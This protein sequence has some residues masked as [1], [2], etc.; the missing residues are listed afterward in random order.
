MDPLK[1]RLGA[2]VADVAD[3]GAALFS[4]VWPRSMAKFEVE[5]LLADGYEAGEPCDVD[6]SV[7]FDGE[8]AEAA[9]RAVRGAGFTLVDNARVAKGRAGVRGRLRLRAYDLSRAVARL[10]RAVAPFGGAAHVIGPAAA[11]V[12]PAP[13]ADVPVTA[14]VVSPVRGDRVPSRAEPAL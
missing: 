1:N 13:A 6:F 11:P 2:V 14:P 12:T 9:L 4:A 8:H 10:D 5:R 3:K 7:E